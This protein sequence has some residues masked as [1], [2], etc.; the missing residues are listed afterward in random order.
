MTVFRDDILAG[1]VALVTGGAT[2]L[3][4]E[5]AHTLAAHG[6]RVVICSRKEDNLKAAVAELT[7]AGAEARHG[8]CDVRDLTQV[9]RVVADT[10]EAYGRLD[11]VVNNAAGNFP[12]PLTGLSSNGFKAVVDIDLIGTFHVS[13][14]AYDAWLG[15]HGG[16]I[17]NISAT[18]QYAGMALQAHVSS[19]K[20]GVDALTRTC[21]IEW[22]PAGVRVNTVSPGGMT[23]TEGL[24]RVTAVRGGGTRSPLGRVG[25][26]SEVANAV[27]FL[28]SDAASYITGATLAVDGGSSLGI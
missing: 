1:R 14:A 27:L 28:V 23:G 4:L 16:S 10:I 13:R 24:A 19:A 15:E 21:A 26:R 17:V 25:E 11:I 9:Q 3:G 22:G 18:I 7:A 2:G 12:A 5:I 6:A 20:A 8:V